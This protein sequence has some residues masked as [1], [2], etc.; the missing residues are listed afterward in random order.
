MEIIVGNHPGSRSLPQVV[1]EDSQPGPDRGPCTASG[2]H[3]TQAKLPFEHADRPLN[4]ATKSLQL[5]KPLSS[6]MGF[7]CFAQTTHFRDGNFLYPR[8][9]KL[10]HVFGT[11]VA[12]IR[13]QLFGLYTDRF[14][15]PQ[16]RKQFRAVVGMAPV[17]LIVNDDSGALLHQLQRAP[18][19]H[20]LVKFPLADGSRLRVVKR[21]DALG[22]RLFSLKLLLGLTEDRLGQ[23]NL[24]EKLLFELGRLIR[25]RTAQRLESLMAFLHGVFGKPGH[26]LKDFSS[27]R[28]ALLG[29]GLGRLTPAEKGPLRCPHMAGDFL[30]QRPPCG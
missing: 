28:F 15:L 21:D 8:L 27:L 29:V 10:H 26:F 20:R 4:A 22:D 9:A 24:F 30:A 17:N 19:L 14:C 25:C 18:K 1:S 13:G 6:L 16:H 3:A 11:V 5:P 7:F 23:F 2:Q 12:P